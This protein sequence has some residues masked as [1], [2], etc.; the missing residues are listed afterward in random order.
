MDAVIAALLSILRRV[1]FPYA[2]PPQSPV[3][4]KKSCRR[5]LQRLDQRSSFFRIPP[6]PPLEKLG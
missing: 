3:R 4:L 5:S 1:M 2:A 6:P